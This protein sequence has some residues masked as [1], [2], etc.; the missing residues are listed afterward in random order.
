MRGLE[1]RPTSGSQRQNPFSMYHPCVI[2]ALPNLLIYSPPTW[3]LTMQK[4][5]IDQ[6]FWEKPPVEFT[7]SDE[8]NLK[9]ICSFSR[10]MIAGTQKDGQKVRIV[11]PYRPTRAVYMGLFLQRAMDEVACEAVF[12]VRL[13][14]PLLP[15]LDISLAT[16]PSLR[17]RFHVPF[18]W[19]LICHPPAIL[20]PDSRNANPDWRVWYFS[21]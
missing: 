19:G 17:R 2:A 20:L 8:R 12:D 14:V 6:E 9:Y 4:L 21:G 3:P 15:V 1:E 16:V 18:T 13:W 5:R 10:Y 11:G 7:P